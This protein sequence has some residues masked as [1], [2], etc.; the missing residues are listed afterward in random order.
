M[1]LLT[2][3]PRGQFTKLLFIRCDKVFETFSKL[4][5]QD[6]RKNIKNNK[7]RT[8]YK[9]INSTGQLSQS[10]R[11]DT[12][13]TGRDFMLRFWS[14]DYGEFIDEGVGGSGKTVRGAK[15]K[16]NKAPGSRFRY[17]SKM[18]PRGSL[19]KWGI[20]KGVKGIRDKEGKFIKRKSMMYLIQRSIFQ[21]GIAPTY[22][23]VDA[24]NKFYQPPLID[25]IEAAYALDVEEIFGDELNEDLK[26]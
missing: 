10:L 21:R 11:A 22:F 3:N 24:F 7:H 5:I 13:Q 6:A 9:N 25:K 15:A 12:M 18:P 17:K 14:T 2:R 23:Y 20:M 16:S 4:V 19:D 26:N 8:K 1:S